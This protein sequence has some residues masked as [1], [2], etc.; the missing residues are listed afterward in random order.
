MHWELGLGSRI[1]AVRN[2]Q[3]SPDVD[4][5]LTRIATAYSTMLCMGYP[6]M[7]RI[8]RTCKLIFTCEQVLNATYALDI[9]LRDLGIYTQSDACSVQ[10]AKQLYVLTGLPIAIDPCIQANAEIG[11]G[12]LCIQ[13]DG[14]ALLKDAMIALPSQLF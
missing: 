10:I 7:N 12:G 1:L 9:S 11:L 2:V 8:Y 13:T 6:Q 5:M 14:Y 3:N 4:T